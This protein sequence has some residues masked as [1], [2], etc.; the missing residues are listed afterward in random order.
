MQ[1]GLTKVWVVIDCDDGKPEFVAAVYLTE[2][3]ANEHIALIGGFFEEVEVRA[4]LHPD[5]ID[6]VKQAARSVEAERERG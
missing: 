1:M 2:A 3:L 4:T 6:P 5:A